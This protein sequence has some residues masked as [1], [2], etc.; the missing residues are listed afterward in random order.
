MNGTSSLPSLPS[1]SAP[2]PFRRPLTILALLLALLC[3]SFVGPATHAQAA[4][5]SRKG[6]SV[7]SVAG[8]SQALAD[9]GGSWYY[10]W[11]SNPGTVARPAGTE[12]VPM[13]WGAGSVTD[14]AL[15]EARQQG[16]QLLGFNEPDMA[17]QADMTVEQALDLWPRLQSTGLRLGAPS[18]AYGGDTPG[19][20][21]DRFMSGA[22]ARGYRVDFIPLH[23][24]GGDFGS[25][26]AEQLRGYLQ[27]VYDR[28][29]KPIWLTEYALIDFS[30]GTPRY[31]SEREQ[32]DFVRSSTAM[33]ES[34]PY[35]ERYSWF[36]LSIE[37]SR[38]GL[39]NGAT[40]N[41]SG[42]A[43]REAGR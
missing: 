43:Y 15:A 39:Y 7:N 29:R 26:A 36:T 17:A 3:A 27:A 42:L 41:A 38:T 40:P 2:S 13:I 12:F 20:W 5:S 10:S 35:V 37:T 32:T 1:S 30:G 4:A 11:A 25:A 19:G 24:Y 18:V 21:L 33:L 16:T 9:L 28:Y 8:A 23:W 34:Q 22:A 6:V 14:A 31:P